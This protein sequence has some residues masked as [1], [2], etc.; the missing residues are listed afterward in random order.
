MPDV[1]KE[2]G[3]GNVANSV[4]NCYAI[5]RVSGHEHLGTRSCCDLA[6]VSGRPSVEQTVP[7]AKIKLYMSSNFPTWDIAFILVYAAKFY[8]MPATVGRV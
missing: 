1:E 7:L 6:R 2:K 5:A 3:P 8:H 4:P